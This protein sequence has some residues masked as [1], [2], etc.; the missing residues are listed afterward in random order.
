MK[1]E[2]LH[3]GLVLMPIAYIQEMSVYHQIQATPIKDNGDLAIVRF[4]LRIP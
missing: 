1:R 3:E 2:G 4:E